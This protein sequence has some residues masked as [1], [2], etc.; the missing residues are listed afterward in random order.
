MGLGLGEVDP[1]EEAEGST[2]EE[3]GM[4]PAASETEPTMPPTDPTMLPTEEPAIL[5]VEG[6]HA[7]LYTRTLLSHDP[8]Y[9][10]RRQE[11]DDWL[12]Q[13]TKENK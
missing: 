9:V 3:C 12:S 2:E 7:D 6:A 13:I 1:G 8:D 5:Y 11:I 4:M 10:S